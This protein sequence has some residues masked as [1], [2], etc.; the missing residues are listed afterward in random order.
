[1][2]LPKTTLEHVRDEAYVTLCRESI[3]EGLRAIEREKTQLVNSRPP[4]GVLAAKR[5]R[6]AFESTRRQADENEAALRSRLARCDRYE[7]WLHRCISADL[8]KYLDAVSPEYRRVSEI[9]RL[10]GEWERRATRL[11]PDILIAYAREM[12]GLRGA[13]ANSGNIA[14]PGD[15]ELAVLRD[16]ALRVE[17]HEDELTVI[18]HQVSAHALAIGLVDVR[19]PALP[20]FK[21]RMWVDWLTTVPLEQAM[22]DVSRAEV[23]IRAF[24]KD[25]QPL[26]GRLQASR[27]CCV[28]RQEQYLQ[29]YWDQLRAHAQAHWVEERDVDEVLDTLAARYDAGIVR[30]QLEVT[31]NPFIAE[32]QAM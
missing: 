19:V 11:L 21:R 26:L 16:I 20:P 1:M 15:E 14:A 25:M 32:Q 7:T 8:A 24:L 30:R 3:Q 17:Q 18:A 28:Q 2:E 22:L 29:Q 9:K 10:L 23:D 4:F 31:H 27:V 6:E 13:V 5:T 12:R